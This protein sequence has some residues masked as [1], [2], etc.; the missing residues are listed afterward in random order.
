M[1]AKEI[2]SLALKL[3]RESLSDIEEYIEIYAGGEMPSACLDGDFT[4]LQL[5]RI[6][7]AMDKLK[8]TIR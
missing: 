2:Q 3:K 1:D 8:E 6:A 5:R 4:A 7:D